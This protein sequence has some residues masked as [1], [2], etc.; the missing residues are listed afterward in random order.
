MSTK[1]VPGYLA[2]PKA[3]D[4]ML[5]YLPSYLD[6]ADDTKMNNFIDHVHQGLRTKP[7]NPFSAPADIE[8]IEKFI[9]AQAKVEH[10]Q[11]QLKQ[12]VI[13]AT[14]CLAVIHQLESKRTHGAANIGSSNSLQIE[15]VRRSIWRASM[16][17][18]RS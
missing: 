10:Y 1:S 17:F 7:T 11:E 18:W 16:R 6:I 12:V 13:K 5:S 9:N 3:V 4:E 14:R 15:R 2:T 8:R